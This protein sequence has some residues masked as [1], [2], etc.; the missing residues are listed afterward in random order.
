MLNESH[1]IEESATQEEEVNLLPLT[2]EDVEWLEGVLDTAAELEIALDNQSISAFFEEAKQT[3]YEKDETQR[4]DPTGYIA[5]VGVLAGQ[6][7]VEEHNGDW[8]LVELPEGNQLGV[9]DPVAEV[10]LLPLD[11]VAE[12]WFGEVDLTIAEFIDECRSDRPDYENPAELPLAE[13][14]GCGCGGCGCN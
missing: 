5:T 3:W 13:E 7:I 2:D 4:E 1:E 11:T 14:S 10:V 9:V 8:V 12:I 6:L